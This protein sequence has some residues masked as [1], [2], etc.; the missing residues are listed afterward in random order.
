MSQN[1]HVYAI[2]CRL[3]VDDAVISGQNVKTLEGYVMVNFEIVGFSG[4]RDIQKNHF[5][6]AGARQT[7]TIALS[8]NVF[9][10]CCRGQVV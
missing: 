8:E 5:V 7:P 9:A 1:E 10:V 4:F 3:E 6:T 2:C